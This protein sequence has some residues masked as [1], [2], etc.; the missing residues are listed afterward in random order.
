MAIKRDYYEVLGVPR[1]VSGE[2]IKK[3]FRKLA[4][5]YHP[6]RNQGDGS[7]DKFKEINEAYEVLSDTE[8][9][10]AYDRFG[11][12]GANGLFGRGFEGFDFS[13][14]GFGDIFDAFFGGATTARRAAQRGGDLE[15]R[16]TISFEEAARGCEQKITLNRT[17][18]CATCHGSGAK[19][20]TSASR[21]PTCNGSGQMRRVQQ[22]IFGR[23]INTAVCNQCHGSGEIIS[24]PCPECKGSGRNRYKRDINLVIPGGVD[25]GSRIRLSGEGEAGLRGGAAG[26]LYLALSVKPHA[27]FTRD[28]DDIIYELSVNFAQAALGTKITVPTIDGDAE[29]KI[30]AG[31]QSGK[32]FRLKD[33]GAAHL[34]RGGHGDQMVELRVVTPESLNRQ[35]RKLFEELAETLGGN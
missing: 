5:Q 16:M 24:D 30:P 11:H 27:F 26:D 21:C 29:L 20:G 32:V 35:Q 7:A 10:A 34:R 25:D 14:G 9:R 33:R 8:R 17:E 28:G 22:S 19:P 12:E 2:D 15:Y 23:F 3:A 31:S 13:F 1:D 18:Q 4:F 6:D